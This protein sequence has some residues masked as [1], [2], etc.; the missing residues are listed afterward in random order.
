MSDVPG[1]YVDPLVSRAKFDREIA[2][3]LSLEADYR[4]RGWFL[5]KVEWPLAI[6]ILGSSKTSP[7]TIVTAVQF[8]YTNYDAE[9]P[10]VRLVSSCRSVFRATSLEQRDTDSTSSH[11]PRSRDGPVRREQAA[12]TSSAGPDAGSFPGRVALSLHCLSQGVSRPPG[13]QRRPMGT[14]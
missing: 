13:T 6:V 11:D 3:Y 8:D 7:P 10:S 14:T 12:T 4:A 1:Q 9:P 2:E 5:V